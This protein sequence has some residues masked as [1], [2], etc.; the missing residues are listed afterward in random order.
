MPKEKS[1][2]LAENNYAELK[3][4]ENLMLSGAR[5]DA[6]PNE[7]AA[8]TTG[9]NGQ[10]QQQHDSN[11]TASSNSTNATA[12]TTSHNARPTQ[13][14]SASAQQQQQQAQHPMVPD[15]T[16]IRTAHDFRFGKSIGEGS[17]S[18]VYLAKDI[19]TRKEYASKCHEPKCSN[20]L[21]VAICFEHCCCCSDT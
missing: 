20:H 21:C 16:K 14:G 6:S 5:K 17:F 15:P 7:T 11:K 13:N 1:S 8:P 18:T 10:Q 4:K 9:N 3:M 2:I 12:N 19:H